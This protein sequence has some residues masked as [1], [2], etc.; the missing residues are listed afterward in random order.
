MKFEWLSPS[1]R[2]DVD[3]IRDYTIE[4]WGRKQATTYLQTISRRIREAE[5]SPFLF[6]IVDGRDDDVRSIRAGSHRILFLADA[7]K[8]LIVRILHDRM[9][10]GDHLD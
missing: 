4:R 3:A 9:N 6:P 10:T 8:F 2:R 5:N 7:E 1:A